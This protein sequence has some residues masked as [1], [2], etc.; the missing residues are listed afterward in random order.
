MYMQH[1]QYTN[2]SQNPYEQNRD[3]VDAHNQ[4]RLKNLNVNNEQEVSYHD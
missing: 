4:P 1:D 3:Y 2:L